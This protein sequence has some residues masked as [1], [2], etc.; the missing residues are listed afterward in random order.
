MYVAISNTIKTHLSSCR[1]NSCL[2]ILGMNKE[3]LIKK[4]DMQAHPEGGYFVETYRSKLSVDTAKGKRSASTAIYFLITKDSISHLHRLRSDEGWH[5]HTGDP[6]KVIEIDSE[7]KLIETIMGT[8]IENGQ[9]MQHFVPAGHWFGS[10]SLGEYSFVGC[11]VSPGFDFEDFEMAKKSDMI[12][13]YPDLKK[14][15]KEFCLD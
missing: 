6:L 7:G 15:L 12:N 4:F 9:V 10:T 13:V 3:L 14:I 8:D 5:F 11:T 1:G 2:L